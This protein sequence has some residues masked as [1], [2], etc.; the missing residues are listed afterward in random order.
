MDN[1]LIKLAS[2]LGHILQAKGLTIAIAESCTGGGIC[3]LL[4]SCAGSSAWFERGF[5]TYSNNS[6][7]QMLGVKVETLKDFGAVSKETALEMVRGALE[8]SEADYAI[9]VT[10]IAGPNGGSMEKPIGTV[11]I[12]LQNAVQ[13]ICHEKHFTGSRHEIRQQTVKFALEALLKSS[14]IN[15]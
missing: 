14:L 15:L 6:K 4:T 11:F 3:Q 7:I 13:S 2:D 5:I 8:N 1:E 12:A 9:S 10:G